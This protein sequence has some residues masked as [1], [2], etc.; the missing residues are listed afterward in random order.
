MKEYRWKCEETGESCSFDNLVECICE[1]QVYSHKNPDLTVRL[2]QFK[3]S[4]EIL[5]TFQAG[6]GRMK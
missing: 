4:R 3:P 2:E 6:H 5:A 1:T